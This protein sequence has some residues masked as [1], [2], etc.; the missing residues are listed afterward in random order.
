MR[1][2][3]I[4]KLVF[5]PQI[6]LSTGMIVRSE[7]CSICE[8]DYADCEH[9]VGM[10][11]WGRFCFRRLKDIRPD[12]VAIVEEPANKLCRLTH[13]SAEGGMRNRMTWRIEP[14]ETQAETLADGQKGLLTKAILLTTYDLAS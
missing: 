3:A 2:D 7:I 14:S 1:L 4:E 11:Y 12:H 13:F 6:F 10:P 9:L 8:K 5:P